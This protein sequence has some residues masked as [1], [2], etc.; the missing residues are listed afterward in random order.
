MGGTL[1]LMSAM[2]VAPR[3]TTVEALILRDKW[4]EREYRNR[5]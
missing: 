1:T 2:A 3:T 5:H 4:T